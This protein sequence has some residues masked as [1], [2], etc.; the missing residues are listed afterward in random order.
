MTKIQFVT[1]KVLHFVY[2]PEILG[3]RDLRRLIKIKCPEV[4]ILDL[5]ISY[6][7][8]KRGYLQASVTCTHAFEVIQSLNGHEFLGRKLI[9][10]WEKE[11]DSEEEH[12]RYIEMQRKRKPTEIPDYLKE[13]LG[14][15]E[16][17]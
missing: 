11:D 3:E 2:I 16:S 14:N 4:E 9:V 17:P 5:K 10:D 7:R 12:R 8:R 15:K 13:I 6:P 1:P